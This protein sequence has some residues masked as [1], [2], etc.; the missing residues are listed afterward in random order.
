MKYRNI[1]NY[2]TIMKETEDTNKWKDSPYTKARK[3][4]VK[5]FIVPKVIYS[6]VFHISIL[7]SFFKEME[8]QFV[9]NYANSL[10]NQHDPQKEGVGSKGITLGFPSVLQCFC[11]QSRMVLA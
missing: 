1:E 8:K 3:F 10:N 11:N 7:K 6:N 9:C 5:I 4:N 2:K